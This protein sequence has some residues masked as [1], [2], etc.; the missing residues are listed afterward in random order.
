MNFFR[1]TIMLYVSLTMHFSLSM[2][3]YNNNQEDFIN[4]IKQGNL[5]TAKEIL[6]TKKDIDVNQQNQS[7]YTPIQVAVMKNYEH[8]VK[9]LITQPIDI[10]VSDE[11]GYTPLRFAVNN[12]SLTIVELL[13]SANANS[14][15]A[16]KSRQADTPLSQAIRAEC[17]TSGDFWLMSNQTFNTTIIECLIAH[18]ALISKDQ[19]GRSVVK[20]AL[21]NQED[22]AKAC[23][24]K[25]LHSVAV[26]LN[27][28]AY[29]TLNAKAFINEQ[30]QELF[31]AI[32][33]DNIKAVTYF[34]K[35]GFTLN[36][37]DKA[38][39]TLIHKAMEYSSTEVTKLLICLLYNAE[40]VHI[41]LMKKNK[42][43]K[44]PLE[45]AIGNGHTTL[46]LLLLSQTQEE[47]QSDISSC[48]IC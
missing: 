43:G 2:L 41:Y 25:Q 8:M 28:K 37:C 3:N 30:R 7:G 14:Q 12:R 35:A 24:N 32:K 42:S 34:L 26:L 46:I 22:L 4:A 31:N 47:P 17:V 6:A 38:E 44:T 16:D 36:T 1:L 45:L 27:N 18:G 33:S 39:N 20:K 10:N 40:K 23:K 11:N 13:L 9:W 19:A 21:K 48:V 5:S 15:I 29:C